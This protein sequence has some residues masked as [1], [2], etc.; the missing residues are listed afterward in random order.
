VRSGVVMRPRQW[1]WLFSP[2]GLSDGW[3]R[4]IGSGALSLRTIHSKAL[5]AHPVLLGRVCSHPV[6]VNGGERLIW[7]S[8]CRK[9]LDL[10]DA[11]TRPEP[12]GLKLV[13]GRLL[14][15]P[16]GPAAFGMYEG[17]SGERCTI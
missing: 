5:A 11:D 13:G 1:A 3:A 10:R 2:A 14:Q 12:S 4:C 8:G 6:E 15:D 9:R 17:P 7:S 16:L